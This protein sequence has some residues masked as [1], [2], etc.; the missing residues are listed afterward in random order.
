[1]VERVLPYRCLSHPD[2][3][4]DPECRDYIA[5]KSAEEAISFVDMYLHPVISTDKAD[6][7]KM[8]KLTLPAYFRPATDSIV[9]DTRG[10]ARHFAKMNEVNKNTEEE[11][12]KDI[13]NVIKDYI[14]NGVSMAFG[15]VAVAVA[16]TAVVLE[17]PYLSEVFGAIKLIGAGTTEVLSASA[18]V[19]GG[20]V[21]AA[22]AE[23]Q[24]EPLKLQT[25]VLQVA[26][27]AP[28]VAVA[29]EDMC[30][31]VPV[32][33]GG[34]S[35]RIPDDE[36]PFE[37]REARRR[38]L[39]RRLKGLDPS[40]GIARD[41]EELNQAMM[42]EMRR[43]GDIFS[44]VVVDGS[45]GREIR[46]TRDP[47][48][49]RL[50]FPG[51]RFVAV[52]KM[53][54]VSPGVARLQNIGTGTLNRVLREMG[55]RNMVQR[56]GEIEF[57]YPVHVRTVGGLRNMLSTGSPMRFLLVRF[58]R[59]GQEFHD[60]RVGVTPRTGDGGLLHS[61]MF[62][63]ARGE[64]VVAAGEIRSD[65]NGGFTINGLSPE[66]PTGSSFVRADPI[67]DDAVAPN[68]VG[69]E[70]MLD[71]IG[72]MARPHGVRV[73]ELWHIAPPVVGGYRQD[74]DQSYDFHSQF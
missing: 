26:Q 11:G 37:T 55:S 27:E 32:R 2:P 45:Y 47:S 44:I 9:Y 34:V 6:L 28:L 54:F 17:I 74:R 70:P 29:E 65:G 23:A 39:E 48:S 40:P 50:A 52:G 8:E 64:Q 31:L 1:M 59:N 41:A 68:R 53:S 36:D 61:Q 72:S 66:F 4:S 38:E 16:E 46:Y 56:N 22:I 63:P 58:F 51:E 7:S 12:E 5:Q 69:L 25:R 57:L 30:V 3:L 42:R 14:T 19:I 15:S 20:T 21:A 73:D 18:I 35:P 71:F 67:W 33:S 62:W 43:E 10:V 24:F 49:N 13:T 60:M